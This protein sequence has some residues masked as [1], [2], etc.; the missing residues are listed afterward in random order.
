[1]PPETSRCVRLLSPACS[2]TTRQ[3]HP[4]GFTLIE[5]L[6]VIAIIGVLVGLL[7][8]AVQGTRE[9]ARR[10][11]CSNNTRQLALAIHGYESA[12]KVFPP[13]MQLTGTLA[14]NN[15]SW[16]IHGRILSFLEEDT[17]AARLDMEK[18]WDDGFTTGSP[19]PAKNWSTVRAMRVKTFACPSEINQAFRTKS[20]VPYVAAFNYAFNFGTWFVFDPA[21]GRGGNGSFHPNSRFAAGRFVDGLSKTL[22]AAEVKAFTPYVRNTTDPGSTFPENVPP[23]APTEITGLATGASAGDIKLGPA[24]NDCTGHT[25][26]PDGRVHHTGFTTT[27]TPNT[28]VPYPSGGA[29]YDFDYNSRQEGNTAAPTYAAITSRSSHPGIVVTAMMDGSVSTIADSIDLAV[30]RA[31]GTRAGGEPAGASLP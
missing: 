15:G 16:G 19:D 23:S 11:S 17:Q 13:S 7:L 14:T 2:T 25:E 6:V 30:W 24:T 1:M 22:C 27:F 10:S 12:R 20:G 31:L 18:A 9:A 26:W 4:S 21:T 8:P 29:V 5:L 3:F 28:K